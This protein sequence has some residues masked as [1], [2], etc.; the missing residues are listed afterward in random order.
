MIGTRFSIL[1]GGVVP[2]PQAAHVPM[3]LGGTW[4]RAVVPR[5]RIHMLSLVPSMPSRL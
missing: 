5:E 2:L 1:I 4:A 3:L